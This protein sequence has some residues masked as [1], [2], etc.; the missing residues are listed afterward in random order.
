[1]IVIRKSNNESVILGRDGEAA[2]II[3][4]RL[5][6]EAPNSEDTPQ[7]DKDL[8]EEAKRILRL[9]GKES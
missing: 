8:K 3:G 9:L 4:L 6:A 2:I 1:M 5:F 7:L